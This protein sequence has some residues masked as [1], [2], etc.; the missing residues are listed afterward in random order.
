MLGWSRRRQQ[1]RRLKAP[2]LFQFFTVWLRQ[3]YASGVAIG[4][5]IGSMAG[6]LLTT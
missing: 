3:D 4:V 5:A 1:R 6:V 2:A